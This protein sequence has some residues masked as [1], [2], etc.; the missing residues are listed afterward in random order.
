MEKKEYSNNR[1]AELRSLMDSM[2]IKG[3]I[4][5]QGLFRK[6]LFIQGTPPPKYLLDAYLLELEHNIELEIEYEIEK[7]QV[8]TT[9]IDE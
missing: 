6:P 5:S 1:L 9:K 4:V 8:S 7:R 2:S 3:E